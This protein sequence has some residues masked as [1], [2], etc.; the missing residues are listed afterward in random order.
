MPRRPNPLQ[1]LEKNE[2]RNRLEKLI[3]FQVCCQFDCKLLSSEIECLTNKSISPSTIR[4]FFNIEFSKFNPST[5]TIRT[6]QEF[7]AKKEKQISTSGNFHDFIL[8]FF[9][10]L[11]FERID[12]LD[13]T[14]HIMYR[15]IA[16]EL[17]NNEALFL[18][19]SDQMAKNE[20]GRKFYYELFPDYD[21]LAKFQYK[22]YEKYL[23]YSQ[24]VNDIVFS[25]CL[26][27]LA[28]N[29]RQRKEEFE[30]Y[31]E[32]LWRYYGFET[33]M[34]PFVKGRFYNILLRFAPERKEELF[35]CIN[36]QLK[37]EK[38]NRKIVFGLFPGFHY[39]VA[40]ALIDSDNLAL[41]REVL[42]EAQNKYA[43]VKEFEWKGYYD[44]FHLF[45]AWADFFEGNKKKALEKLQQVDDSKFYFITKGY[46]QRRKD[47]LLKEIEKQFKSSLD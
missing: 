31:L 46:F 16:I 40:D 35:E 8:Q 4:R 13:P 6:F 15:R 5:F 37:I 7:I 2:L 22:G 38:P 1:E 36:R 44:H 32:N 21:I 10:P 18:S 28:A 34:H 23:Q 42:N 12:I 14:T 25:T 11:H 9:S 26:L 47:Q 33:E 27:V 41:L 29:E 19:I 3:G 24:S 39:F 43:K 17:R 20:N 45:S 30:K